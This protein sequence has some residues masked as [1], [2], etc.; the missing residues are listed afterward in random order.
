MNKETLE[1]KI[2]TLEKSLREF[3]LHLNNIPGE[4]L[5]Q[6]PAEDA[7]SAVQVVEHLLSSEGGTLGYMMKKSSGGWDA[8]ETTGAEQ[9]ENSSKLNSR[10]ASNER[11][12]APAILPQP[13]NELKTDDVEVQWRSLRKKLY[14]FVR[15]IE[16]VHYD[17]LVFR[18]PAAGMLNILQTLEFLNLH[19][20]HHI[21]Q[22]ERIALAV[23]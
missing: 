15:Q 2:E 23:K 18:Q 11:F 19:L 21:A 12:A 13:P 4:K 20:R 14:E 5:H 10:L 3:F 8:L 7:W 9:I 16:P 22:L 6:Q 17:K 1:E